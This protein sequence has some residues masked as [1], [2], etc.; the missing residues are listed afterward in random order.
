ME[1]TV[2]PSAART[3]TPTSVDVPVGR[4]R[5]L[6][7]VIDITAGATLSIT[8]KIEGVDTLSGKTYTLLVGSALTGVGTTV[9]RVFPGAAPAANTVANDVLPETIRITMT[10]GNANSATYTVAAHLLR[11]L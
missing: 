2:Y 7:L 3:A 8:P 9:L 4:A 6:E 5:A 11:G 1:S 10:H